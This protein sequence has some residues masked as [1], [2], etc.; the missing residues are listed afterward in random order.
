M[1]I[2]QRLSEVPEQ[3]RTKLKN[4]GGG[5]LN[6]VFYW[7]TMCEAPQ[8]D[9]PTGTLAADIEK[10]C[11]SFEEFKSAF[12]AA[13]TSLF[14]SGYV[15]LCESKEG[16]LTIVST[17]NQVCSYVVEIRDTIQWNPS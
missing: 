3:W 2:L 10:T 12:S 8:Q 17:Q 16:E 13:A 6:H 15:W 1:E 11:G 5:F 7:E 14:G 9:T 4:N